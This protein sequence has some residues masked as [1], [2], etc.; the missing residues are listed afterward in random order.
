M[1][2]LGIQAS[3]NRDGLTSNIVQKVLDGFESEGGEVELL[4][5]NHLDIKPCKAC[6]RGWGEC[7]G[8]SCI[9]EDDFQTVREKIGIAEALVFVTPVYFGDLSESAKRFLDR[10][11]RTEAF[12]GAKTCYN[13]RVIGVTVAG[14]SGNG[15]ARA[16]VNLESYFKTIGFEIVDLVTVTKF[17]KDHKYDMLE[18]AGKRLAQGAPGIATRR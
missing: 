15:A 6:E 13:T 5:L 7:R 1:K 9:L 11:R 4:H 18:I 3:P 10:L 12:S 14:G 8:G 16:L 2:C 17:S